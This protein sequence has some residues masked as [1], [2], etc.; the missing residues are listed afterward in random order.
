MS[1]WPVPDLMRDDIY[2]LEPRALSSRG[3]RLILLDVDNTLAPYTVNEPTQRM[4]DWVRGMRDA[5]LEV[6]ILSNNRGER[7]EL[8]ARA[9][10]VDFVKKAKKPFTAAARAALAGLGVA[11]EQA[12]V[13]GD[14]IYTDTLC[15]KALGATAVLVRPIKFTN[16]FLRLR[17]WLEAPFRLAGRIKSKKEREHEQ[18]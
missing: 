2:A 18:H 5:G 15:A 17:Y 13:L 12:A 4:R 10:G 11:P 1:L 3:V 16:I 8:F 9:L 7:P 14:Q 6:F